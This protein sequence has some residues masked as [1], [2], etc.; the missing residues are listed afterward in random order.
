MFWYGIIFLAVFAIAY[1]TMPKPQAPQV[2]TFEAP[3][4]EEGV[5]IIVVFGTRDI[6]Q[7]NVV[8]YGDVSTVPVQKKGGKK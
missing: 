5:S 3:T 2:G 6:S 8:W 4:A 1:A 7:S